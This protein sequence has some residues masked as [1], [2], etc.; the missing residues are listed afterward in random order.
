MSLRDRH[1][2]K[3]SLRTLCSFMEGLDFKTLCTCVSMLSSKSPWAST[4]TA[5]SRNICAVHAISITNLIYV[6]PSKTID[7]SPSRKKGGEKKK[8]KKKPLSHSQYNLKAP[9]FHEKTAEGLQSQPHK[10]G[11]WTFTTWTGPTYLSSH[12]LF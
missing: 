8:K 7:S 4:N 9:F 12:P 6:L 2:M 10:R 11:G 1:S 3:D 5:I